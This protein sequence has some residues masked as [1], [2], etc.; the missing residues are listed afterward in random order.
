MGMDAMQTPAPATAP[1]P[2]E[3]MKK[4]I[5]ENKDMAALSYAWILAFV[6]YFTKRESA[7][8][9]FHAK[10]GIVLFVLSI[11]FWMIPFVNRLLE[12]VVLALCVIGFL[13][14]AQ[15]EW[16]QLP[17]VYPLSRGDFKAVRATWRDA[18][19][20]LVRFWKQLRRKRESPVENEPIVTPPPPPTNSL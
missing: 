8:V 2:D 20:S 19:Q 10:Q 15:G 1:G 13:A 3:A 4:D 5:E 12:L 6:L 11:V 16:K 17:V 14:A 18:L 9:R 7:F